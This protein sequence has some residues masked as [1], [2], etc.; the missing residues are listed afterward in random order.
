MTFINI[1]FIAIYCKMVG[2]LNNIYC[3]TVGHLIENVLKKSNTPPM[4]NPSP[5][6]WG[7]TLI[8]A[9]YYSVNGWNIYSLIF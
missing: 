3:P 4:P 7:L 1:V 8:G 6:L 9:L 2:H 5:P